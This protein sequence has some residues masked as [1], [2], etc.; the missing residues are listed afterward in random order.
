MRGRIS[1]PDKIALLFESDQRCVTL[2]Q[3]ILDLIYERGVGL[4]FP[5][6]LGVMR[7]VEEQLIKDHTDD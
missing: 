6:V 4:P 2:F 5:A 7:L 1:D 3:S